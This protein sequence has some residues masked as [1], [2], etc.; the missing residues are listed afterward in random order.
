MNTAIDYC[1]IHQYH[2]NKCHVKYNQD[3]KIPKIEAEIFQAK[4][5]NLFVKFVK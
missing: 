1:L 5:P 4:H 2:L 3:N